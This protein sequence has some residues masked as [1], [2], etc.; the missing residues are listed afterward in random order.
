ME[1]KYFLF[2]GAIHLLFVALIFVIFDLNLRGLILVFLS[3]VL[4][5]ADHL[6]FIKKKGVNYWIKVWRSHIV[7]SYPLHNFLTLF[8]FSI[9][10]LLIFDPE[11]FIIGVC[12]LSVTLHLLWDFIED[13]FILKMGISHW[14]V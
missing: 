12:S 9:G 8:I 4:I 5:D 3:S 14:K 10:S 11:F 13:A 2:H 7:K 1:F 6:P